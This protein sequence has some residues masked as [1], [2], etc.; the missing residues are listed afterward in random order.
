MLTS[1]EFIYSLVTDDT[2]DKLTEIMSFKFLNIVIT[3]FLS[4]AI[5]HICDISSGRY[6]LKGT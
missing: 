3:S 4:E 1:E 5:S 6:S 2:L